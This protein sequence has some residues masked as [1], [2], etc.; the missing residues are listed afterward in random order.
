M[1]G[2]DFNQDIKDCIPTSVTHLTFG[3]RFDQILGKE[4]D[5]E[6]LV[7]QDEYLQSMNIFCQNLFPFVLNQIYGKVQALWQSWN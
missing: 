1:F 7:R 2:D 3:F 6:Q 4:N 5:M